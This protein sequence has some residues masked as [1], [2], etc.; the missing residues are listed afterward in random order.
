MD[1]KDLSQ[2]KLDNIDQ[3]E[4]D[5]S[6]VL[7]EK[8]EPA[9]FRTEGVLFGE[10][11]PKMHA[12]DYLRS[13]MGWVYA[14]VTAIA[15]AV[16]KVEWKL[17]KT[18]AKGEITEVLDHPALDLL[19]KV[20][21][22]TTAF[23]HYWLT[24]QYKELTGEAPWFLD[25]GKN[26]DGEP[27]GILL[28]RPDRLKVV[29][30][31]DKNSDEIISKYVYTQD[32]GQEFDIKPSELILL[33]YP[34]PINQFR[35]KG[36]LEA[37]ATTVDVDNYSEEYNKRFFF[38]SGRPDMVLET[39]N[40][41]S[42]QQKLELRDSVNRMYRGVRNA[43]KTAILESGLKLHPMAISQKDMDF[44]EQ[45]KF[46]MTKILSIF[47]VPKS[48]VAISDDV[49]LANAKIA[50]Y[51]FAKW[52]IKPKLTSLA[53][54]LNEF[55]LPMFKGT[56]NMFLSFEDPVPM[57]I[58]LNLK[59]YQSMLTLGWGSL[60][61]VRA[62][63]NL[64]DLGPEGDKV[65]IPNTVRELGTPAPGS[66]FA[67]IDGKPARRQD[68][69]GIIDRSGGGFLKA[70]LNANQVTKA[71]EKTDNVIKKIESRIDDLAL[72]ITKNSYHKKAQEAARRKAELME[73]RKE[74]V[75][76][77]LKAADNY[78]KHFDTGMKLVFDNQ[79]KKIL[80][81]VPQ[82]AVNDDFYIDEEEETQ[83]MVRIFT[84][85][86]KE[87]IRQQGSRAALLAGQGRTGFDLASKAVQDYL[88]NRVFDFSTEVNAETNKQI[89][90]ALA[91][92]TKNGEGITEIRKRIENLFDDM[93]K[94][95]AERI[96]R[97]EVIRA[98]NFATTE[99]YEQSG[100]VDSVE[101]L[102][103]DDE[104]TCQWCGPLNGKV[105]PLGDTFFQKGSQF[106]GKDGG[107]LN[108]DYENINFPPLHPSCRCTVVP[109]IK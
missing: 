1:I 102:T 108:L 53:S 24:Q 18:D 56:E 90:E 34:D 88:K 57:D 43:H 7:I 50:E 97:S 20:N 78:E 92:A 41:L 81:K 39:D 80:A 98:S 2:K 29:Q 26:G 52:T 100:V 94:V 73:S 42:K 31:N 68:N 104:R 32:F 72:Q 86:E 76:A 25:R 8:D 11:P 79:R 89:G 61:E 70:K 83:I 27:T 46:S 96:A 23:D 103:T 60:N 109:I 21:S 93:T 82:K 15:D 9:G 28:L 87:I 16:A 12:E 65:Y 75:G 36:T 44:L 58:E 4:K 3:L 106:E 91:E 13:S 38:N 17:Y 63:Q 48:I 85:L 40:K 54:Q 22:Y 101:W 10:T 14:C 71:Q 66:L 51:I 33:R 30:N 37:A 6:S 45:Q 105:I 59:R 67:S 64:E 55:F 49:N 77:Y 107:I 62:E 5:L 69:K 74:F 84:P 99:A 95:R 47:R 35:G 19:Y